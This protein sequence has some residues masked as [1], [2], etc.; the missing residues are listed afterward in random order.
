[1]PRQSI[2]ATEEDPDGV[3]TAESAYPVRPEIADARAF[4]AKH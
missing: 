4:I 1:M 2:G 3:G